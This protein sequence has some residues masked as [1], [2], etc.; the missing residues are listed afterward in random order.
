M[1]NLYAITEIDSI[2]EVYMTVLGQEWTGN[3]AKQIRT[4]LKLSFNPITNTFT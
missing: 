1:T 4:M 3:E 2:T